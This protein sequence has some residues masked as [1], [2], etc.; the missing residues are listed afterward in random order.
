MSETMDSSQDPEE[1]IDG[2]V[3]VL[4][5]LEDRDDASDPLT[6]QLVTFTKAL[7]E[8]QT[9]TTLFELLSRLTLEMTNRLNSR[10]V[11]GLYAGYYGIVPTPGIKQPPEARSPRRMETALL[12][13]FGRVFSLG[14]YPETIKYLLSLFSAYE[15]HSGFVTGRLP[16]YLRDTRG[17]DI[18]DHLHHAVRQPVNLEY[19][20]QYIDRKSRVVPYTTFK[21]LLGLATTKAE[22]VE[23]L[24]RYYRLNFTTG[25]RK[26]ESSQLCLLEQA[27]DHGAQTKSLSPAGL[28]AILQEK[29]EETKLLM[30]H[31]RNTFL[32]TVKI[33]HFGENVSADVCEVFFEFLESLC[34][35]DWLNELFDDQVEAYFKDLKLLKLFMGH[36]MGG[37][38]T[39]DA[40][41]L[42]ACCSPGLV[43][44]AELAIAHRAD[45]N[46]T[47]DEGFT[48]LSAALGQ[49]DLPTVELLLI[50]GASVNNEAFYNLVGDLIASCHYQDLTAKVELVLCFT[51]TQAAPGGYP[52]KSRFRNQVS[53][54]ITQELLVELVNL[55]LYS[56]LSDD[57]SYTYDDDA[58][59]ERGIE[60]KETLLERKARLVPRAKEV[61]RLLR[62]LFRVILNLNH[63]GLVRRSH[64]NPH[65]LAI[66]LQ[67]HSEQLSP[68][69]KKARWWIM[70]KLAKKGVDLKSPSIIKAHPWITQ[71]KPQ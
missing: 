4:S 22:S 13:F 49:S 2:F 9:D 7:E 43:E 19:L 5:K 35:R 32:M 16:A 50:S 55:Y 24:L 58:H 61:K 38:Q 60:L 3:G 14:P 71:E 40:I 28:R 33:K 70:K 45:V 47:D 15:L 29:A 53:R 46:V 8:V 57:P 41:L 68:A 25:K 42:K 62:L 6:L 59:W 17:V 21:T 23:A 51:A 52:A 1:K 64:I 65:N 26:Y 56:L 63:L 12:V 10:L 34:L 27:I 20:L 37:Q 18:I 67:G 39:Y 11:D 54:Y 30:P 36:Q 69:A 48:P 31:Q 44:I 66:A